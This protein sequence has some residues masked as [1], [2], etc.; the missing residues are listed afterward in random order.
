MCMCVC[1]GAKVYVFEASLCHAP[2]Y[3]PRS[4]MEG[5]AFQNLPSQKGMFA[6]AAKNSRTLN[7]KPETLDPKP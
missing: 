6:K 4:F 7:P 5:G 1:I 2:H 3:R